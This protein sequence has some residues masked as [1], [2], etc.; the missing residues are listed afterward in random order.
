[1]TE[2]PELPE[3]MFFRVEELYDRSNRRRLYVRLMMKRKRLGITYNSLVGQRKSEFSVSKEYR[4]G[5]YEESDRAIAQTANNLYD[6]YK[7]RVAEKENRTRL[8]GEY[9]PKT[10]KDK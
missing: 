6:A 5:L 4:S 9:P 3:G 2:M 8:V 10:L 1:M 7:R